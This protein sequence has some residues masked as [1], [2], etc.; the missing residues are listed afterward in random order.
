MKK[1]LAPMAA[2]LLLSV[3]VGSAVASTGTISFAGTLS[4]PTCTVSGLTDSITFRTASLAEVGP[5]AHGTVIDNKSINVN[6]TACPAGVNTAKLK[7]NFTPD[8]SGSR[9]EADPGSTMGGATMVVRQGYAYISNDNVIDAPIISGEA[10]FEN[11]AI[12]IMRVRSGAHGAV[13]F[14]PGVR[15][16]S[17]NLSMSYE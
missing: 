16:A 12:Q 1:K 7:V 5:M 13:T 6:V 15:T 4:T 11:L 2:A 8:E 9:I 3:G 17:V 10:E 14:T